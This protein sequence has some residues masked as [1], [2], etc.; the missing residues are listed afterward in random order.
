MCSSVLCAFSPNIYVPHF[1]V[2]S[3]AIQYVFTLLHV[4]ST[5]R[6]PPARKSSHFLTPFVFPSLDFF[7]AYSDIPSIPPFLAGWTRW[8]RSWLDVLFVFF[9]HHFFVSSRLFFT[10]VFRF[11]PYFVFFRPFTTELQYGLL[12]S[13]TYRTRFFRTLNST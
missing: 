10:L 6:G 1:P 9:S 13:V 12:T 5:P 7:I 3:K 8:G 4:L 11:I 2:Y